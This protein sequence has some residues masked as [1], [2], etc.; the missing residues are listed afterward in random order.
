MAAIPWGPIL[1]TLPSL[2]DAAG[3]L[4]KKADEPKTSL[5][6]IT[7]PDSHKK[8]EAVIKR[9]E[10]FE[11][12]ESEQTK[13]LQQTIE[14]LQNVA[15]SSAAIAKRANVALGVACASLLV[16]FLAILR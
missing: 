2:L 7:P 15:V 11:T 4:F 5:A 8:L 13:L 6:G 10:Y 1:T 9:L 14:Q 3:R 16:A 12:L